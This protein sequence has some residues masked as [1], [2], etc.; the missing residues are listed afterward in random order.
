MNRYNSNLLDTLYSYSE[1]SLVSREPADVCCAFVNFNALQKL[2]KLNVFSK[3]SN[4]N[5]PNFSKLHTYTL[6]TSAG[7]SGLTDFQQ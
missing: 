1:T 3:L 5:R 2:N 4:T 7:R 6:L